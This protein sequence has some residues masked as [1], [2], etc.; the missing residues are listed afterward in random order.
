[1]FDLCTVSWFRDI[2]AICNIIVSC[3]FGFPALIL[4]QVHTKNYFANKTTNER[5]ARSARSA[6]VADSDD[7]TSVGGDTAASAKNR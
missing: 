5:F 2:I 6:S 1:M 7:G 3:F 4:C